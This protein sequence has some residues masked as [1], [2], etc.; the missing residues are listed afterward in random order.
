MW[1]KFIRHIT[2]KAY[3]EEFNIFQNIINNKNNQIKNLKARLR[4]TTNT[5]LF[6]NDERK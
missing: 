2:K 6:L 5:L 4:E 1:K 3:E